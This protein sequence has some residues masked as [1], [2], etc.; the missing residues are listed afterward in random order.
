VPNS[1][2][3]STVWPVD[4]L[5]EPVVHASPADGPTGLVGIAAAVVAVALMMPAAPDDLAAPQRLD[6]QQR[7]A[8]VAAHEDRSG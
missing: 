5:D 3:R 8:A 2:S 1:S 4:G 7:T 6:D